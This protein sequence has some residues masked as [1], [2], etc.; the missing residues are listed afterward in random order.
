MVLGLVDQENPLGCSPQRL[1]R[2]T[3]ADDHDQGAFVVLLL[4]ALVGFVP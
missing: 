4:V 1:G 2:K 3:I